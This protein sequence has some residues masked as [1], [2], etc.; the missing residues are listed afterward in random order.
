MQ[1]WKQ[2][3]QGSCI[4]RRFIGL[5]VLIIFLALAFVPISVVP[6][7]AADEQQAAYKL[8]DVVISATKMETDISK[9]PTN[10]NIITKEDIEKYEARDITDLLK[11]VP[12]LKISGLGYGSP[13]IGSFSTRGSEPDIRGV[14][15]MVNGIDWSKGSGMFSPPR[16]P[17]DD[18]E[19]IE[20]IKTPS[21]MFGDQGSGGVINIITRIS[22]KPLEAKA[23]LGFGS[24]GAEKYFSVLNGRKNNTE[25]LIDANLTKTDGY[26]DNAYYNGTNIYSRIN[27]SVDESSSLTFSGFVLDASGNFPSAL[28]LDQFNEDPRQNPPVKGETEAES[29]LAAVVYDKSFGSLA[30]KAKLAVNGDDASSYGSTKH[31][32]YDEFAIWP[33]LSFSWQQGFGSMFNQLTSGVEYRN[34]TMDTLTHS[35]T[36]GVFTALISEREREDD[37]WGVYF[38]DE[39][40]AMDALT[41]TAGVRYDSYELDSVD[42]ID[43]SGTFNCSDSAWSPKLGASY[44]FSEAVNLFAGFNS[45]FRSVVRGVTTSAINSS[46]KPEKVY[47]YEIGLRGAPLPYLSYNMA[48]FQTDATDKIIRIADDPATYDNAGETQGRGIEVGIDLNH[49]SG[50]YGSLNYTFQNSEYIEYTVDG[51]PYNDNQLPRVSDHL[52]GFSVGYRNE[53]LGNIRFYSNYASE[54]YLDSANLVELDGYWVHNVKYTKRFTSID[55]QVE[56]Y[57]AGENLAD[58]QYIEFGYGGVSGG[59]QWES[60]YPAMGRIISAGLTAYF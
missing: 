49:Q 46:L 4:G 24:Y 45:G 19:R 12:G 47:A 30:L 15:I 50:I 18:I 11:Q 6:T 54:K 23:G 36:D 1:Q 44:R 51:V 29:W 39:L 37:V 3:K 2:K 34:Y 59:V 14:K 31:H 43:A 32:V 25:Y 33:E 7:I 13:S 27:Y 41:I 52:F 53:L 28:T 60:V 5:F 16:V 40:Q 42:T 48:I 56:L 22:D 10:V 58:E 38:Q 17:V 20:I 21:A 8:E 35:H 26:Q 57:I 55:P 9:S